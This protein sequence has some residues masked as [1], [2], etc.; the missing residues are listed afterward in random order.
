MA[1]TISGSVAAEGLS[2][3]GRSTTVPNSRKFLTSCEIVCLVGG[4]EC[5]P[6]RALHFV[7]TSF[8]DSPL[9]KKSSTISEKMQKKSPKDFL[10]MFNIFILIS[11]RKLNSI[12]SYSK[13][14]LYD[15]FTFTPY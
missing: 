5:F 12:P 2:D 7:C 9:V 1:S 6:W 8:G 3:R 14:K 10:L 4:T 15:N 13:I 11:F